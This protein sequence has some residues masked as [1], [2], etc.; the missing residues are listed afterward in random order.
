M[1]KGSLL[2]FRGW[3]LG[4]GWA[5]TPV[6]RPTPPDSQGQELLKGG[7]GANGVQRGAACKTAQSAVSHPETGHRQSDQRHPDCLKGG[8]SSFPGSLWARFPGQ[9]SEVR[10][11]VSWPP[12]G[13]HVVGI[14]RRAGLSASAA[15]PP[16]R[17]QSRSCSP[18]GGAKGPRLCSVTEPRLFGPG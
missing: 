5:R 13:H 11:R 2:Y 4:Q 14:F 8:A 16:G 1:G 9:V 12:S 6:Q 15:P 7:S 10:Q 3:Q 18:R 17:A